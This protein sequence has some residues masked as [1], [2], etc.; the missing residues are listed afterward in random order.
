MSIMIG[1]GLELNMNS[2]FSYSHLI[3]IVYVWICNGDEHN[4]TKRKYNRNYDFMILVF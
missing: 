2:Y 4:E 1:W 3:R